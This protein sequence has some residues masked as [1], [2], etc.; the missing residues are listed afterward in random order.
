MLQLVTQM[1]LQGAPQHVLVERRMEG[2]HRAV[3]D[4]L[5]EFEQRLGRI[6]S[7]SNCTGAQA[8]NQHTGAEFEFAALQGSLE[9]STEID[10]TILDHHGADG[11]YPVLVHIQPGRFQVEHYPALLAQA[12]FTQ[13]GDRRQ[14]LKTLLQVCGQARAGWAQ[15]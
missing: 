7:G 6:A 5:H 8:V 11:Q 10:C 14:A 1:I 2:Q 3:A 12:A 4:K 9:L 15:P 13:P